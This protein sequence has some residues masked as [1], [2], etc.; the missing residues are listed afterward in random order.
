MLLKPCQQGQ[1]EETQPRG[2]RTPIAM[3]Y[4]GSREYH[5]MLFTDC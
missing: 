3:R 4:R 2:S 1:G 5:A